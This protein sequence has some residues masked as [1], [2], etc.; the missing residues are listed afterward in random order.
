MVC[1][2]PGVYHTKYVAYI[3]SRNEDRV[4]LKI[5]GGFNNKATEFHSNEMHWDDMARWIPCTYRV[6]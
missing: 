6:N 2:K 3:E 4:L 5:L 1:S